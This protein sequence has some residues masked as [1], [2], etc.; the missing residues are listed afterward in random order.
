[1]TAIYINIFHPNLLKIVIKGFPTNLLS[2]H[3]GQLKIHFSVQHLGTCT[4]TLNIDPKH[5]YHSFSV[6]VPQFL[7]FNVYWIMCFTVYVEP[8]FG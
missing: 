6:S 4:N 7:C 8:Y 3:I 2:L 1:M 5:F